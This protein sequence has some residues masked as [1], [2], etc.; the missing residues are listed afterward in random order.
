MKKKSKAKTKV[1]FILAI[2]FIVAGTI[3][4]LYVGG[5]LMFIKPI[6]GC[7][8]MFDA[9]M[10]TALA[11]GKA[12]ISCIFA[13]VVGVVIFYVGLIIGRILLEVA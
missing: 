12:V 9:G 3:G 8:A 1:I 11:V 5:W 13:S 7:C 6:I 2:M 4:G 10:L